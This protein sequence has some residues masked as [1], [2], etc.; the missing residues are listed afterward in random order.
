MK[1]RIKTTNLKE[2][3]IYALCATLIKAGYTVRRGREKAASSGKTTRY[4]YFVEFWEG[5]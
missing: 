5:V 1:Q 3:E 4:D 2:D